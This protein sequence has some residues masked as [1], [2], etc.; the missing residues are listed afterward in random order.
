[1]ATLW[2]VQVS[3]ESDGRAF[4][5]IVRDDDRSVAEM[6]AQSAVSSDGWTDV[7]VLRSGLIA[8]DRLSERDAVFQ[9]AAAAARDLGWAIIRYR[10]TI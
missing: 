1:M 7:R 3:A 4:N 10:P 2:I 5:V 8:E 9:G 6:T